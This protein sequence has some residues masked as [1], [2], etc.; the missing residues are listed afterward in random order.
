MQQPGDHIDIWVVERALGSGGMGSVYRC[1][2]RSASRILAA[3]KGLDTGLRRHPESEAR[4]VREAEILFHLDH[5]NIVKVRN[6]RTDTDPPYLEMEFVEGESLEDHLQRGPL[7]QS[8]GLK[9]MR[10]CSSALCYLH[11]QGVCH[12]DIKPANLLIQPDGVVKLVDFG[13]AVEMDATRITQQGM[14]FGT[15]SYAPPEW[16]APDRLDARLWDVYALGVVF[17]EALTGAL[18][19]PVSGQGSSRQQA[20]QVIVGKQGHPPLDPGPRFHDSVRSLIRDMTHADPE[21]RLGSMA[22][23]K[24]RVRA[25]PEGSVDA[26]ASPAP[27]PGRP[28]STW[29]P[30]TSDPTEPAGPQTA[31]VT[32]PPHR[33][34]IPAQTNSFRVSRRTGLFAAA[35]LLLFLVAG[36]GATGVGLAALV[37]YTQRSSSRDVEIKVQGPEQVDVQL[38]SLVANEREGPTLRF[39]QVPIGQTLEARWATGGSGCE[40]LACFGEGCPVW[41]AHGSVPIE[42]VQGSEILRRSI[43]VPEPSTHSVTLLLP[44]L[45]EHRGEPPVGTLGD[46]VGVP[47]EEGLRFDEVLP[48]RHPLRLRIGTCGLEVPA[49]GPGGASECP[50]GCSAYDGDLEVPWDGFATPPSRELAAPASRPSS[51]SPRQPAGATGSAGTQDPGATEAATTAIAPATPKLSGQI[52]VAQFSEWL[53][54]HPSWQR[55]GVNGSQ[56]G[57]NYLRNWD[58]AT[59][60]GA[61]SAAD[62]VFVSHRAARSYCSSVFGTDLPDLYGTDEIEH[63]QLEW[64]RLESSPDKPVMRSRDQKLELGVENGTA[65]GTFRCIRR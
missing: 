62:A 8:R 28:P 24:Q 48:G 4:F 29:P 13:L 16:I 49:C 45:E 43:T 19:F 50:E 10:Q 35:L 34:A 15:V 31:E 61:L 5:P 41:C 20:M 26:F 1:H 57:Q 51:K 38:G 32:Q 64:R 60:W 27:H 6:V 54:S 63:G 39:A 37:S 12:R 9:L 47:I 3:V 65:G 23:V 46:R 44:G 56:Q 18:A 14:A 7:S 58:G 33:P 40:V 22:A 59:P 30:G 11:E 52:T 55:G 53:E 42:I 25:L 21:Q 2:N 36:M 17:F